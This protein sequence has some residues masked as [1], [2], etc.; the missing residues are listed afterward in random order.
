MHG[1]TESTAG[2]GYQVEVNLKAYEVASGKQLATKVGKSNQLASPEKGNATSQAVG[3]A[4]PKILE[5]IQGYWSIMAKEGVKAKVVFRGD[6]SNSK[7]KRRLRK[8]MKSLN[9]YIDEC[10]DTCEWEKGPSPTRRCR[11]THRCTR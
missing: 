9:E 10:N 4:M 11:C 8:L 2:G 1:L 3:R 5:Q 6:F 7:V